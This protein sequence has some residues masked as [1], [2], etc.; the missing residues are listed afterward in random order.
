MKLVNGDIIAIARG[1]KSDKIAAVGEAILRAG[2]K[3]MEVSLSDEGE[4]IACLKEL[5][6][7]FGDNLR[8]G[9]GTVV[10]PDQ[11][12]RALAAGAKYIITPGWDRELTKIIM[13]KK[14]PIL[15]GVFTPSEI[16]QA[17]NEGLT[18]LKLFPAGNVSPSFVKNIKGPFPAAEFVGVGGINKENIRDYY[19]AG[20]FSFAIGSDLIPKLAD[21]SVLSRIEKSAKEYLSIMKELSANE[22]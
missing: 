9:A 16:M 3:Y 12:D 7:Q 15:P 18:Q 22:V 17:L 5:N 13:G 10:R 21:E 4:G 14:I 2:L 1:V 8:L 11:V 20:C 6:R 19:K